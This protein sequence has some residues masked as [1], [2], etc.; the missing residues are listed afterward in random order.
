LDVG[1][2]AGLPGVVLAIACPNL[3]FTL[4]DSNSKKTGFVQQTLIEIG[5]DNVKVC[6]ARAEEFKVQEKFDGI[7]S[8]AFTDLGG[9]MRVTRHL[10]APQG[11]W[12]AMKGMPQQEL[13]GVP[14]D[15]VVDRVIQLNVP[16]LLAARSLVVATQREGGVA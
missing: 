1:C 10:L 12:L 5:L 15:C 2:G 3:Q 9:F 11:G 13:A 16:G 7:V 4:L 6:C 8:R 14:D